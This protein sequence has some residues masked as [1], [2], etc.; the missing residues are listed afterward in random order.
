MI[1][2]AAHASSGHWIARQSPALGINTAATLVLALR[3][4]ETVR[5]GCENHECKTKCITDAISELTPIFLTVIQIRN[6]GE[7]AAIK[8]KLHWT[9]VVMDDG[10]DLCIGLQSDV[11]NSSKCSPYTSFVV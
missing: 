1:A 5:A 10:E 8:K 11:I 7:V 3:S 2:W 6:W 4:P 9:N